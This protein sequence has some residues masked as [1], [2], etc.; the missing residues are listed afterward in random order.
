MFYKEDKLDTFSNEVNS[1]KSA[2]SK[3]YGLATGIN[4]TEKNDN[5]RFKDSA[6]AGEMIYIY[7]CF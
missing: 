4:N 7:I 2:S 6:G 3:S 1:G 5:I